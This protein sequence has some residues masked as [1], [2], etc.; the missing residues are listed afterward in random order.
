MSNEPQIVIEDAP[1]ILE[2][3]SENM[4]GPKVIELGSDQ[5]EILEV[6]MQGISGAATS[7]EKIEKAGENIS[8]MKVVYINPSDEKVYKASNLDNN[9]RDTLYGITTTAA[10][11]NA[12]IKVKTFG[13]VE[14]SGWNW[15]TSGNK[16]LFVGTDG[17]L[18]QTPPVS[19]Y[20]A[21]IG[22]VKSATKIWFDFT[23]VVI[24]A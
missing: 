22:F 18:T 15:N 5:V 12:A 21:R 3:F 16:N 7:T 10:A 2:V 1:I 8:A 11:T 17:N 19:G 9:S 14:N 6:G 13:E 23:D 4:G 20:S 24:L